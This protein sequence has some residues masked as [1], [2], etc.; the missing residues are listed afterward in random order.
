M[1][2]NAKN[3][4]AVMELETAEQYAEIKVEEMTSTVPNVKGVDTKQ[5]YVELKPIL[6][7]C[8]EQNKGLIK[9]NQ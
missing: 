2:D 4:T 7:E 8:C 9:N 3:F 6:E 5:R 1:I